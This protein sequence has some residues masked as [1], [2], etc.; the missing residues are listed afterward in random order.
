VF[1]QR[2]VDEFDTP[3][4]LTTPTV[5]YHV[6]VAIGT[7]HLELP[8]PCRVCQVLE[9]V[10]DATIITPSDCLGSMLTLLKNRRGRQISLKYMDGDRILLEYKLPWQEVVS[11]LHDQVE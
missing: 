4:L 9:P 10:V 5:P 7:G 3:V 2:L 1:H 11:D 8:R 6:L